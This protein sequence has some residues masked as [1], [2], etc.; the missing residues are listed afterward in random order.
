MLSCFI[1]QQR[2]QH[3]VVNHRSNQS[4]KQRIQTMQPMSNRAILY[5]ES[6]QLQH[7]EQKLRINFKLMSTCKQILH[8]E[9]QGQSSLKTQN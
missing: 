2:T 8:H 7:T 5:H 3:Y 1:V 9:Q 6:I 4:L